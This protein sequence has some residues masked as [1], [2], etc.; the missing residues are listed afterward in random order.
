MN[1]LIAAI[2]F[3]APQ[4]LISSKCFLVREKMRGVVK[5]KR[6]LSREKSNI[7]SIFFSRN[8]PK[9][10]ALLNC[11]LAF[12]SPF[13]FT[14]NSKWFEPRSISGLSNVIVR[15]SVVLTKTVGDSDERFNNLS[16]S[17]LQ[18][19]SDFVWSVDGNYV[20]GDGPDWSI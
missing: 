11:A 15:V 12:K 18:S 7:L 20:P 2:T 13:T 5:I 16:G 1:V 14:S 6:Q 19:Q 4:P 8:V 17:H 10:G 9:E 3:K